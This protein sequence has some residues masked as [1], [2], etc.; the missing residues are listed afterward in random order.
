MISSRKSKRV[1]LLP[2][3]LM[4]WGAF[5]WVGA[6][7]SAAQELVT[8]TPV[9]ASIPTLAP[10]PIQVAQT[11][12]PTRTPTVPGQALLEAKADAGD[13]NVR[14]EPD[15]DS[16]RI[17]SIRAGDTYPVLGRYFR[18]YQFQFDLSPSGRGWVFEELVNIQ[19]DP[20]TILDLSVEALPTEDPVQAALTQTQEA[21]TQTPGGIL[22]ATA[23]IRVLSVPGAVVGEAA[24]VDGGLTGTPAALPTFTYPPNLVAAVPTALD[25]NP[26]T[27]TASPDFTT[28]TISEGV[29]PIV[30]IIILGGLGLLGLAVSSLRR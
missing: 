4:L 22:T 14:A 26:V 10:P 17:G 18:W 8:A 3:L 13:V 12:T 25:S 23:E 1:V 27:P 28:L 7:I 21:L 29:P 11:N 9:R 16:D 24:S 19:G 30:P 2:G 5:T 6:S 15:I 20:S